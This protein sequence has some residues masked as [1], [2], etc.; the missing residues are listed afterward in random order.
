MFRAKKSITLSI[1]TAFTL[2]VSGCGPTNEAGPA[3]QPNQQ[4]AAKSG[5][6]DPENAQE[7]GLKGA[8]IGQGI[9]EAM[10]ALKPD[11]YEFMDAVS[12]ATLSID[13]LAAGEGSVAMGMLMIGQSQL[14]VKVKA[15]AVQ[16]IMTGGISPADAPN[17][18][19][20]R[21]LALYDSPSKVKELYGE[22]ASAEKDW[23]YEGSKQRMTLS[24][25]NDQV[26]GMKFEPV[27]Q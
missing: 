20:S 5:A 8:Y 3:E 17:I 10:D 7:Y 2:M 9:K 6:F 24:V 15:G 4:Q 22:P 11:K 25:H 14:I 23:V 26:I 12:R 19:T 16:S 1:L 27:G 13:Q 18:T 21:G